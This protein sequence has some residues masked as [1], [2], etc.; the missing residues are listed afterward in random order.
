MNKPNTFIRFE[1]GMEDRVTA[2]YGPFPWVQMTYSEMNTEINGEHISIADFDG[3][4]WFISTE[5]AKLQGLSSDAFW[6][7]VII[8]NG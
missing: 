4:C 5:F 2:T 6:S 7:D 1:A 8:H 3:N